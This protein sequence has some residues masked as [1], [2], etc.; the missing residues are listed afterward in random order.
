LVVQIVGT[1]TGPP[2]TS[3]YSVPN[4]AWVLGARVVAQGV[5]LGPV[6]GQAISNPAVY[7]HW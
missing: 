4:A 1:T 3:G 7:V 2:I 5:T 6:A